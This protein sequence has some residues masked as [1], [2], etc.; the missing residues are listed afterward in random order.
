[1]QTTHSMEEADVL[2]DRIAIMAHGRLRAIG[3]AVSLKSKFG[4]GYRI[5]I[6]T[7][8]GRRHEVKREVTALV[9][10]AVLE[11]ESAGALLYQFTGESVSLIPKLIRVLEA[12]ATG[13]IRAWGISQATLEEVFLHVIRDANPEGYTSTMPQ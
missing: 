4:A 10:L 7:D 9:P 12:N 11:D 2:G 8:Q 13:V 6:V 1:M 3:N 5:S